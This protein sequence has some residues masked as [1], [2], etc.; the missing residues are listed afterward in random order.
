M[1]G[2]REHV[3]MV[4]C[5]A[6][7]RKKKCATCGGD[8]TIDI[9]EGNRPCR[10]CGGSGTCV[11]CEGSGEYARTRTKLEPLLIPQAG[12]KLCWQCDGQRHCG[13]CRGSG[14]IE[15][16]TFCKV[17]DF[18]CGACIDCNGDGEVKREPDMDAF[19]RVMAQPA[20]LA[21]R[22][23]L[24]EEWKASRNP[25]AELLE[26]QL[27]YRLNRTLD[28]GTEI[29]QLIAQRGRAWA[30]RV[31]D[32]VP[33]YRFY[34]GLVGQAHVPG[35][36][37]FELLPQLLALQPIQIVMVTEPWGPLEDIARSPMLGKLSAIS[38]DGA[39]A[40]FG[41]HCA[42]ALAN[43]PAAASL[44][45]LWLGRCAI[46]RAGFE[47]LAASPYLTK[48]KYLSPC[49]HVVQENPCNEYDPWVFWRSPLWDELEEKYGP[50]P[51]LELPECDPLGWPPEPDEFVLVNDY[52]QDRE[53][54]RLEKLAVEV[55][56]LEAGDEDQQI[57]AGAKRQRLLI[58]LDVYGLLTGQPEVGKRVAAY[59]TLRAY[60]D[61]CIQMASYY[62]SAARKR[63]VGD[64][65][66]LKPTDGHV[67]LDW[68]RT[69][70]NYAPAGVAAHDWLALCERNFIDPMPKATGTRFVRL[71][72][73]THALSYRIEATGEPML[74]RAEPA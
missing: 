17:C 63:L 50:R 58:E 5:P 60:H 33:R 72:G 40:A 4:G 25:Q 55:D 24:L 45:V 3:D 43:N 27:A 44:A 39:E 56:Q 51:W 65:T 34:R 7:R 13:R 67:S 15:D 11:T 49:V 12:Y 29:A 21:A 6:C 73:T 2:A 18:H 61:A 64:P 48:A 57:T 59:P 71:H 47:A 68:F 66:P 8:G 53:L 70:T 16:G 54:V 42:I 14:R 23:A 10:T 26:K 31:A 28:L 22:Y 32:L 74:W 37:F 52:I 20:S 35:E 9:G 38:F 69:P 1:T 46:G 62:A 30:G 19:D 36:R 41:D